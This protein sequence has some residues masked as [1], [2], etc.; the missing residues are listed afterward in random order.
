M[1]WH[2][3]PLIMGELATYSPSSTMML[4]R[5]TS[6]ADCVKKADIAWTYG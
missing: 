6:T 5:T 4:A 3:A 2:A 1:V